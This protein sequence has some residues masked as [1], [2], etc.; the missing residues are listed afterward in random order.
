MVLTW[1]GENDAANGAWKG[2]ESRARKLIEADPEDAS[3]QYF[4]GAS[5]IRQKK[6]YDAARKALKAAADAGYDAAMVE[7]Q[8]GLS[9]LLQ[10]KWQQA[11]DAFDKV[12]KSEPRFAHLYYY[13]ALAWD[14]LK[15]T[16][17]LLNDLDQFVKLAP[18]APE[19][20]TAHAI[21]SSAN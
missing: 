9:Y 4:L 16:D 3:A 19:A 18:D 5:L 1:L 17:M 15:R 20:K 7:F 13:R 21:L 11:K 6:D 2:T 10:E 8:T 14:K 12:E